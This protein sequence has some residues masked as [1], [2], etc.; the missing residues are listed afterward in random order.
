MLLVVVTKTCVHASF[1]ESRSFGLPGNRGLAG[2]AR[3][4]A[5]P[6]AITFGRRDCTRERVAPT[7]RR[8]ALTFRRV[9]LTGRRVAFTFRRVGLPFRRVVFTSRRAELTCRRGP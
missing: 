6:V 3:R 2:R 5:A 7:L 8:V 9:A 4:I 1:R